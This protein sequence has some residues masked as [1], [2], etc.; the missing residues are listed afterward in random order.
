V[1]HEPPEVPEG[2]LRLAAEQFKINTEKKIMTR[3]T[4]NQRR[5]SNDDEGEEG[6]GRERDERHLSQHARRM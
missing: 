2:A 4:T 6:E 1:L 5:R 3:Q